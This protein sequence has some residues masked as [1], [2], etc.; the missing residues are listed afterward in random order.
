VILTLSDNLKPIISD[1]LR[2]VCLRIAA[3]LPD[4]EVHHIGAT[5]I[6]GA[7]T[8]GDLDV[9]LRVEADEFHAAV[10]KL[11]GAFAVKQPENWDPYFASFGSDTDFAMPVGVQLVIKDSEADFFLF[12][13]DYLISHPESLAHYNLAKQGSASLEAK[14]YWAAKDRVLA[15][16][17]SLKSNPAQPVGTANAG[18]CHAACDRMSDRMPTTKSKIEGCT[19]RASSRHG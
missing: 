1:V 13:R 4:V 12:V 14:D 10:E 6:T 5:A 18:I 2:R 16:I 7:L 11:R 3:A 15:Q 19:R 8:K 17:L 9:V